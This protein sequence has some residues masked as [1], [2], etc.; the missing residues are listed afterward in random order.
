MV[1]KI[2]EKPSDFFRV[3]SAC[4]TGRMVKS[5]RKVT[6]FLVLCIAYIKNA[7]TF[8]LPIRK[9]GKGKRN[10]EQRNEKK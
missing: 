7:C 2:V 6:I 3:V 4:A 5:H 10:K 1:L 8:A 9:E